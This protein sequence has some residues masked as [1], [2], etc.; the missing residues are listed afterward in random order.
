MYLLKPFFFF[1]IKV[2]YLQVNL[3]GSGINTNSVYDIQFGPENVSK[4]LSQRTYLSSRE[5]HWIKYLPNTY[6]SVDFPSLLLLH[7][8][9][10]FLLRLKREFVD[11]GSTVILIGHWH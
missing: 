7:H 8:K 5:K 1:L 3:F 9:L 6:F 10:L 4:A 11:S 2:K